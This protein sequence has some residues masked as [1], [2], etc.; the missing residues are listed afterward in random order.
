MKYL[1]IVTL[2]GAAL[3]LNG[4]NQKEEKPLIDQ[5]KLCVFSD[6]KSL[7]ECKNGELA[8][9][10][11]NSWG[12][13]QLPIVIASQYCDFNYQIMYNDSGFV[14]VFNNLR[15]PKVKK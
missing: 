9:F 10:A 6:E 5:S 13:E 3:F 1:L 14:C 4:C 8:M 7:K 2:V 11:P 12:N 15:A